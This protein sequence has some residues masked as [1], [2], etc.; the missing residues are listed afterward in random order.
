MEECAQTRGVFELLNRVFKVML[1]KPGFK[2]QVAL[3]LNHID[4]DSV[5]DLIRTLIWE[6]VGVVLSVAD[7]LPKIANSCIKVA[8][9]TL[10][11]VNDHFPPEFLREVLRII[12]ADI[13]FMALVS[14]QTGFNQIMDAIAPLFN[15]NAIESGTQAVTGKG[16]EA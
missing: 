8:D 13:D 4:P 3:L 7:A 5:P 11:Q 12:L 2:T 16:G 9:E 15:Q 1:N 6:D 14:V 10:K